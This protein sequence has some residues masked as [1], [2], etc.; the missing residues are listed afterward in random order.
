VQSLVKPFAA[1]VVLGAVLVASELG[2][3]FLLL[4]AKNLEGRS[5]AN[6]GAGGSV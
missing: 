6:G 1:H 4:F 3:L 2:C 5:R